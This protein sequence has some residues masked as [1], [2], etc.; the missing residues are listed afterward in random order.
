MFWMDAWSNDAAGKDTLAVHKED[1]TVVQE[2]RHH[3]DI[4]SVKSREGL[5]ATAVFLVDPLV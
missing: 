3:L 5:S 2:G 1:S 4:R